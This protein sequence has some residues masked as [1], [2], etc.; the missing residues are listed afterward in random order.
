MREQLGLAPVYLF[1]FGALGILIPFWAPYLRDLGLDPVQ[2]GQIMAVY[3]AWRL[4]A[5]TAWGWMADHSGRRMLLVRL[6]AIFSAVAFAL[7]SRRTDYAGLLVSM[8]LFAI[9]WTALIPQYEANTLSVL[10]PRIA[11]YGR[12]RL[13]GSVGFILMVVAGGWWFDLNG[14]DS[15]PTIAAALIGLVAL[16]SFLTPSGPQVSEEPDQLPL[17]KVLRQPRVIALLLVALLVQ[18]AFGPYY[19]FFTVYLEELGYARTT[20]GILWALGVAAEIAV[21]L[22]SPWLFRVFSR[23]SLLV[24]ALGF[25][26]LRW[27]LTAAFADNLALLVFAQLLHM[28]SFGLFHAVAVVCVHDFF[29]GKTHGRGQAL[30][31]SAGFGAGGALGSLYSGYSWS[32]FGPQAMFWIAAGLVAVALIITVVWIHPDNVEDELAAEWSE[33]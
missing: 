19:V 9:F 10:G 6:A 1:Y 26:V 5:P 29:P 24:G 21:F 31:S 12:I 28:A 30:Y 4:V 14:L 20:I 25:A 23:R 8:S 3:L 2:I 13:W 7:V 22:Y 33:E 16:S 11:S 27:C 17:G 18:A 15:V 32:L